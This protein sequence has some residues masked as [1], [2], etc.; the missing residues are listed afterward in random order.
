LTKYSIVLSARR[1]IVAVPVTLEV[2]AGT[3]SSPLSETL[4]TLPNLSTDLTSGFS[5][6]DVDVHLP[7]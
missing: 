5:A 3:S 1:S 7:L 4:M 6:V 2:M